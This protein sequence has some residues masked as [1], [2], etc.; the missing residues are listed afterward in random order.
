M[1]GSHSRGKGHRYERLIASRLRE[2]GYSV[3][4]GL[5][6]RAGYECADVE[7]DPNE[8]EGWEF[9]YWVECAHYHQGGLI[10]NKY[11]QAVEASK[12]QDKPVA[13]FVH[14]DGGEDL[15]AVSLETF[16][17]LVSASQSPLDEEG[18]D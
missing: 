11:A 7:F 3:R 4:R 5:Q 13:V 1:A 14:E 12:G 9:P 17:E 18:G 6:S 16:L 10:F 2:E 15:V 8:E